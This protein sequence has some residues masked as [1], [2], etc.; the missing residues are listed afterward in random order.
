VEGE[1]ER[2]MVQILRGNRKITDSEGSQALPALPGKDTSMR[3]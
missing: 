1:E 3:R 2:D